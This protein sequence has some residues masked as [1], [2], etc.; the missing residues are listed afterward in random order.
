MK[1]STNSTEVKVGAA[2]IAAAVL[3]ALM[4]M[5]LGGFSLTTK[6]YPIQAVFS[7]VGGLKDG[8]IVRYAGVDVGRVQSVEMTTTGV[9]VNLRIFDHVR[10]PRGSVFTIASEGLLGEKYI[11]I[12]PPNK[13]SEHNLHPG[14]VVVGAEAQGIDSVMASADKTMAEM[15]TLLAHFNDLVGDPAVK[16]SLKQALLRSKAI[17]QNMEELTAA[18]ARMAVQNESDIRTMVGNLQV[19]SENLR[20]LSARVDTMVATLDNNGETARDMREMLHNMKN[21]SARIESIATSLDGIA[22]DPET[23]RNIKATLRN[24][25]EASEK[26]NRMLGK[27]DSMKIGGD[28]DFFYNPEQ[29]KYRTDI[30][31]R[32]DTSEKDFALLGFSNLGEGTKTT[33]QMGRRNGDLDFR[34][35]LMDSKLGLGV[36]NHLSKNWI[37]SVDAYDP[38][39]LRW[40]VRSQWRIAPQTWLV[41]QTDSA[42]K[43]TRESTYVGV[44]TSF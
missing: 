2:T 1:A 9:T 14:E 32:L 33:L 20:N 31:F 44:R 35:G 10:I 15:R 34:A 29:R 27:F 28:V 6:G 18:L 4:I 38:N 17:A 22:S 8:A 21:A 13:P 42:G 26:A 25:R 12:L 5:Y 23:S 36:D 43:N 41:G 7:Q 40:K 3:L 37:V 30:D 11:T 16:D 19:M 24:A 39:D